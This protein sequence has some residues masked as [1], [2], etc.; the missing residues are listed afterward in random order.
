MRSC[1]CLYLPSCQSSFNKT[2]EINARVSCN[3]L[4]L[5][6]R[7]VDEVMY[8]YNYFCRLTVCNAARSSIHMPRGLPKYACWLTLVN[9]QRDCLSRLRS[10]LKSKGCEWKESPLTILK[11]ICIFGDFSTYSFN[12]SAYLKLVVLFLGFKFRIL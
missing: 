4:H 7:P 11:I 10:G 2:I 8:V 5:V 6:S 12:S 3:C 1:N 9:P